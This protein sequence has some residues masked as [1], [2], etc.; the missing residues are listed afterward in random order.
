M[1]QNSNQTLANLFRIIR[2]ANVNNITIHLPT[3]FHINELME[4]EKVEPSSEVGEVEEEEENE[5]KFV[6]VVS[7]VKKGL[8]GDEKAL[9]IGPETLSTYQEIIKTAKTV[10]LLGP[11][12]EFT[13]SEYGYGCRGME[14]SFFFLS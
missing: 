8:K 10:V 13:L 2:K 3:D 1:T 7:T 9:D 11:T 14:F 4:A 12:G 6:P 5:I